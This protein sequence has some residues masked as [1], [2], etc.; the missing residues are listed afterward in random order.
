MGLPTNALIRNPFAS[1]TGRYEMEFVL[2]DLDRA[3]SASFA[4][5]SPERLIDLRRHIVASV[6]AKNRSLFREVMT[7]YAI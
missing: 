7:T 2:K 6:S 1:F 4:A 3:L 5:L